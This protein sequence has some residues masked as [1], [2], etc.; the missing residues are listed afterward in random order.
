MNILR[1]ID[2]KLSFV[3]LFNVKIMKTNFSLLF[4][5]K[6]AKKLCIGIRFCLSAYYC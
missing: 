1:K 4:Y 3:S 5:L 6:K 2:C